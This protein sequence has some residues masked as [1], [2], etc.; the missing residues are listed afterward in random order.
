MAKTK[1]LQTSFAS[2]E[3]SPSL[4]G[5]VDRDV[6]YNG[7]ERIRNAYVGPL[8]GVIKRPGTKYIGNTTGDKVARL[9]PFQF[10]IV[11]TYLMVFTDKEL[12]IYRDGDLKATVTGGVIET[13]TE[14]VIQEMKFTQSLDTLI[15]VHP[16]V[17]PIQIL[18]VS[19]TSWT[20]STISLT[21]PNFDFGSGAEAVWSSTRGWPVSA[22][23]FQQRLWFGGSKSRPTAVWGSKVAGFFDFTT[24]E[25]P[26]DGIAV[27]IEDDE[28]NAIVNIVGGR[29]LQIFTGAGEYFVPLNIDRTVTPENFSL[30][31]ATRHGSSFALPISSDGATMFVDLSGRVV[32]E[33]L[34]LDIEQSYVTD[35]ISFL[36]EHLIRSPRYTALQKSSDRLPGE[37]AYFVN[38]DG[39]IAVLNRRRAQNFIAWSLWETS[40]DYEDI[41]VTG[42]E[43]YV[44]VKRGDQRF[45]ERFDYDYYTDA[46]T[47]Y[48]DT[49]KTTW[50]GIAYLEGQEVFVRSQAGYP[51]LNNE[52]DDGEITI[53]REEEGIEVGL[54]WSVTIKSLPPSDQE[55][56]LVGEKRRIVSANFQLKD[57]NSFTARSGRQE[58][59]VALNRFGGI[60]LGEPPPL[61]SGW[62]RVPMR[63]YSR[64]PSVEVSQSR[65]VNFELLSMGI[66]VTT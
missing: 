27:T 46:G 33:Y 47:I 62:K 50:T 20:P 32:R 13:L 5:R 17:A 35:D 10:N 19:D 28:S 57:S 4:R 15:L 56:R 24:G 59:R 52:V 21:I 53:E 48:S 3:I 6:Y 36:S 44:V 31:L 61:F 49:A 63:G 51:L 11:Q 8:G 12:K 7:A 45:I 16:D 60:V 39:T 55:G 18:R 9:I 2:G 65:P 54:P 41:A 1:I 37:Y 25:N 22:T 58:I 30:E 66:E 42:N 40:G 38:D 14:S 64:E 23:F 34:Y 43:I 26:A 29:T